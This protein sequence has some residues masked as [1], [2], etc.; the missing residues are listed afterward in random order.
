MSK[1]SPPH[2]ETFVNFLYEKNC[3]KTLIHNVL[4]KNF[5][6]ARA[7]RFNE[8]EVKEKKEDRQAS[9]GSRIIQKKPNVIWHRY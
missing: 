4:A 1:A 5:M 8:D 2:I 7:M 9:S 6:D 3:P